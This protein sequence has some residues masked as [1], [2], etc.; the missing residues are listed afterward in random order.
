MQMERIQRTEKK[1]GKRNIFLFLIQTSLL[2]VM[3]QVFLW[4]HYKSTVLTLPPDERLGSR[5]ERMILN[6]TMPKNL[7]RERGLG[8]LTPRSQGCC[9]GSGTSAGRPG[10]RQLR[11]PSDHG[12]Q[13]PKEKLTLPLTQSSRSGVPRGSF[14]SV[15][16]PGQQSQA[17]TVPNWL[18][19]NLLMSFSSLI[20]KQHS[21]KEKFTLTVGK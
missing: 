14:P 9:W 5:E 13:G 8:S 3:R 7:S 20:S 6:Q 18:S 1:W 2:W 17:V 12:G 11:S 16:V 10:H 19:P 15:S 4:I 21:Q